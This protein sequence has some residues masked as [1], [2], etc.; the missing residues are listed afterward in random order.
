V[1]VNTS[2]ALNR[3]LQS[4]D[5]TDEVLANNTNLASRFNTGPIGH[6]LVGGVELS[7]ESSV[8]YA[9][10]GP[11]AP[12]ADLYDPNP[13]DPYPG[14]IVRSGASTD[15]AALSTAAYLFD[16][17]SIGQHLELTGGLRWDR[18]DV[19]YTS[20]AITGVPTSFARTDMMTSGRGGVIYKPRQE[21]SIYFGY[22]TSFNPSA[23]GLSLAAANVDLEPEKARNLEA[24]TKWDLFR[25]QLSATAAIFRTIKTNARTPGVNPGDPPTVLEGEHSVSGIEFGI[26]GRIRTWWTAIVNYAHMN[27]VIEASNTPAEVNQNLA[28]TPEHTLS[29]WSTFDL[30]GGVGLGGG[31]QYMDSVF[32]NATNTASVP[33]YWLINATASYAVNSHLTV[34][35]NGSN[36]ADEAYVDRIG[37][38]HYVPGPG[39]QLMVTATIKR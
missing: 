34:R 15:G 25:Q 36:L 14:P 13:D 6:A 27:S 23:E 16:T 33:S 12:A 9:R 28:L 7:T 39:R 24:G 21:G 38:G 37:G 4:R 22:G 5:M 10:I 26:S 8:N 20:I 3:Q 18:F 1:A 29:L 19:D 30:P 31:A 17:V 11:V 32:R 2:T 35:F